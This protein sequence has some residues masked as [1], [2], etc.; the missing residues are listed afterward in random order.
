[1]REVRLLVKE[2]QREVNAQ[3]EVGFK[4]LINKRRKQGK[5]IRERERETYIMRPGD[6]NA[7]EEA[8]P[9]NP[10][11]VFAS[12]RGGEDEPNPIDLDGL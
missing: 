12:P 5:M 7:P 11:P 9:F 10:P 4:D 2:R 8:K 6:R 3:V 1:L